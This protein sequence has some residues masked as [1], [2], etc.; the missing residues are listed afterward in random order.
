M[1]D[2]LELLSSK[3]VP[4]ADSERTFPVPRAQETQAF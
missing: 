3:T 2:L 4:K 1:G